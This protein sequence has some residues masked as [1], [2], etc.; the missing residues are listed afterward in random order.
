MG[1]YAR[2]GKHDIKIGTC[3]NMY[4]LRYDDRYRVSHIPGNVDPKRDFDLRWR[5]PFPDED[6]LG[7][8]GYDDY[9]RGTPLLMRTSTGTDYFRAPALAENPGT[10]QLRHECGLLV[11]LPCYHGEKLPDISEGRAF[12]NGKGYFYELAFVKNTRDGLAPIIRCK[13]CEHLWRM[14]WDEVLPFIHDEKLRARLEAYARLHE[15]A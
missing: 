8:G 12:W 14:E 2:L 7:P 9:A 3:E 10:L 5:L 4:Y 15:T 11:N 1:E 13:A 6:N